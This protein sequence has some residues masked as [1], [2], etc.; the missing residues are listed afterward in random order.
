[1]NTLCAVT[2]ISWIITFSLTAALMIIT[3]AK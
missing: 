2:L 1:M 3:Y